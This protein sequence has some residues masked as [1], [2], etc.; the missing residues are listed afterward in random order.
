M[1]E[2]KTGFIGNSSYGK[3]QFLLYDKEIE[4]Y[5]GH[6]VAENNKYYILDSSYN[7]ILCI[8]SGNVA[9]VINLLSHGE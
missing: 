2:I 1:S 4:P 8:P 6:L 3:W 5:L 9:C 7:V